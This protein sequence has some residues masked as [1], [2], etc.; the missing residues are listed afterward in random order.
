LLVK[1][2]QSD[3]LLLELILD[4]RSVKETLEGIEKLELTNDGV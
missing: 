3:V 4:D 2:K 1:L